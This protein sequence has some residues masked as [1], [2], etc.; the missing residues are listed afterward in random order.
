MSNIYVGIKDNNAYIV[1]KGRGTAEYCSD[2]TACIQEILS[3]GNIENVYF[4][5]ENASHLDSSFL[6]LILSV[7]KKISTQEE[8]VFLLN[9]SEKIIDI[10]QIMGLDSF[11]PTIND[12]SLTCLECSIEINQ[13]L[14]NSIEDIKLLLE[15]H[16]N[17]METSSENHRRFALVEKVF[18]KELEQKQY[19]H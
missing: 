7:K 8:N 1:V 2:L 15:S 5:M 17:I 6:G 16:Q 14:E 13:K 19:H 18:Q 10:F 4:D 11:I 12:K 3:K 9:P